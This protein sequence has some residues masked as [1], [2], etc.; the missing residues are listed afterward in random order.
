MNER[1]KKEIEH[2]TDRYSDSFS[3]YVRLLRCLL[4]HADLDSDD[5]EYIEIQLD[6]LWV[7]LTESEQEAISYMARLRIL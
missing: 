5:R 1:S 3:E 7:D 6:S 4:S 2:H